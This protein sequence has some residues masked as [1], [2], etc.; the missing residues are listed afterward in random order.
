MCTYIYI[1]IYTYR[2]VY[3]YIYVYIVGR[4][5]QINYKFIPTGLFR[6]CPLINPLMSGQP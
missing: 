1:Y 4:K 5:R 3:K 2:D 6:G